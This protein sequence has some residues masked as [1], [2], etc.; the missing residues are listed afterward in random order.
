MPCLDHILIREFGDF[1]VRQPNFL[2]PQPLQRELDRLDA[3]HLDLTLDPFFFKVI[4]VE[5]HR[6]GHGLAL[7]GLLLA[8]DLDAFARVFTRLADMGPLGTGEL[9]CGRQ[10]QVLHGPEADPLGLALALDP[11][12]IKRPGGSHIDAEPDRC[13]GRVIS[14]PIWLA[15]GVVDEEDLAAKPELRALV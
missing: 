9:V 8:R 6:L 5:L 7:H 2:A 15:A 12:L 3:A 10:R 4:D 11:H 14:E 1:P 13:A